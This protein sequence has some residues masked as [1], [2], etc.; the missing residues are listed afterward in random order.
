M[1]TRK[2]VAIEALKRSGSGEP[3]TSRPNAL[4]PARSGSSTVERTV[5]ASSSQPTASNSL[6]GPQYGARR[7]LANRRTSSD[8]PCAYQASACSGASFHKRSVAWG[9]MKCL[10]RP[11]AMADGISAGTRV[12]SNCWV[13]P[14]KRLAIATLSSAWRISSAMR[15][16]RLR[17]LSRMTSIWRSCSETARPIRGL[18]SL[19]SPNRA[20][21][22]TKNCG[23]SSKY[24]AMAAESRGAVM[25]GLQVGETGHFT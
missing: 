12:R 25:C 8:T 4:P 21:C 14:W 23:L 18:V 10:T 7:L 3:S 22:S 11:S 5:C 16:S 6:F 2:S 24:C 15:S 20:A 13:Q 17:Y 1:W 9:T 19:T